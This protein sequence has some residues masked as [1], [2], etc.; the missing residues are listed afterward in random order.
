M[1]SFFSESVNSDQVTRLN[2]LGKETIIF[3]LEA[4]AVYAGCSVLLQPAAIK[5]SD[6]VVLF[7]DNDAVLGRI[8]SGKSGLGLDGRIIQNILEWEESMGAVAWYERVPSAANISDDPSRGI[9]CGLDPKL[10][11]NI[12]IL[13][14]VDEIVS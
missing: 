5:S 3:E 4:L 13:E 14:L 6:R 9:L 7:L 8:I 10:R 2:P 12:S 1:L 11:V